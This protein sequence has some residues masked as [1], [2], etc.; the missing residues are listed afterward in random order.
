[1]AK[2]AHAT[3]RVSLGSKGSFNVRKGALHRALGIAEDKPI[4]ESKL[5]GHH[6]GKLGRMI[7]SARGF[8]GMHHGS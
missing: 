4:P 5:K 7:A 6:H 3:K 8:A 1:M 2:F